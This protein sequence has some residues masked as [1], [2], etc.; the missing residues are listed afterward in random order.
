MC[1]E[2]V[3]TNSLKLNLAPPKKTLTKRNE[4]KELSTKNYDNSIVGM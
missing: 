4:S 1:Q 3:P 2:D